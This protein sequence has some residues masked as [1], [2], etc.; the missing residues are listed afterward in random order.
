M[1]VYLARFG[2]LGP[3][4]IGSSSSVYQRLEMLQAPLWDDMILLRLLEGG[5]NEE[6]R[7]HARFAAQRIKKEW[8]TYTQDMMGDLG[9]LDLQRDPTRALPEIKRLHWRD[10]VRIARSSALRGWMLRVGLFEDDLSKLVGTAPSTVAQ[11]ILYGSRPRSG[12]AA[13][14]VRLSDGELLDA[15]GARTP[16]LPLAEAA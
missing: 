15:F 8:F 3:V 4:K 2:V 7:L 10:P 13:L 6:R 12:V 11:W 16:V 1:P 14:L 9:L 5:L